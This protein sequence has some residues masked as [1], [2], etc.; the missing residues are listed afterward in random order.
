M[1]RPLRC[2]FRLDHLQHLADR[3]VDGFD[4]VWDAW[5]R[6]NDSVGSEGRELGFEERSVHVRG[7]LARVVV[8]SLEGLKDRNEG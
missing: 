8:E 2:S 6:H 3:P 5:E 1:R 4:W 7:L